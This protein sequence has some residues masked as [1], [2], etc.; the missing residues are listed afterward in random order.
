MIAAAAGTDEI[1]RLKCALREAG[2][3]QNTG[4]H[5][6]LFRVG[7]GRRGRGGAVCKENKEH[8]T[9]ERRGFPNRWPA[10]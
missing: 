7:G 2:Q 1:I 9:R 6:L 3:R 5:L 4:K 8:G 10:S